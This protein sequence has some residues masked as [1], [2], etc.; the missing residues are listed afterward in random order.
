MKIIEY[1]NYSRPN[2]HRL[3]TENSEYFLKILPLPLGIICI[4]QIPH[5][6]APVRERATQPPHS[7][8]TTSP[9]KKNN[10]KP[11][12][13][14][15]K[16][17]Y[18]NKFAKILKLI[19]RTPSRLWNFIA[20]PSTCVIP[21]H[22]VFRSRCDGSVFRRRVGG[23]RVQGKWIVERWRGLVVVVMMVVVDYLLYGR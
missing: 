21:H 23:R 5:P 19:T 6:S 9:K 3:A 13:Q 16:E 7:P 15:K 12:H 8:P 22:I 11:K 2:A 4:P 14:S 18:N 1:K 10:K 17:Q 20:R